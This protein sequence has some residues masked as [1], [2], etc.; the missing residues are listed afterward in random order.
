MR[1]LIALSLA[2]TLSH[3]Q[4]GP[5]AGPQPVREPPNQRGHMLRILVPAI[6]ILACGGVVCH[7][8]LEPA[9]ARDSIPVRV[10]QFS[11]LP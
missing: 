5:L 9:F 1:H 4:L 10:G 6:G 8:N 2:L 11:E 7:D 3:P